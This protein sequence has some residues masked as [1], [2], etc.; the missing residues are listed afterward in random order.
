M[1]ARRPTSSRRRLDAESALPRRAL[2]RRVRPRRRRPRRRRQGA[3]ARASTRRCRP[4]RRASRRTC[5]PTRTTSPSSSTTWQSSTASSEGEIALAGRGRRANAG[6][7]TPTSSRSCCP[8]GI[9]LLASLDDRAAAPPH[10]GGVPRPRTPRRRPRQPRSSCSRSRGCGPSAPRLLGFPVHAAYVTAEQTA[11]SPEAVVADMLGRLAPPAARNAAPSRRLQR[12]APGDR[13]TSTRASPSP[14]RPHDWA[15]YSR[16][17]APERR[18]TSTR[19]PCAPYFEAERVLRDGVFF[20]ATQLYGLDLRRA[21][22]TSSAYHPDARVFE[23]HRGRRRARR[24]LRARPLHARLEARRRVDEPARVAVGP[25]RTAAR[26]SSTTSTCRSRR[27]ARRR[28]SARRGRRR[29][30]TSSA[31]PCTA[32]SPA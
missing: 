29:C 17:G 26:S 7:T 19:P 22:T 3:P 18:T 24:P 9:P 23:V 5:S 21:R 14:S 25:A 31:T 1:R 13:W 11:G 6:S 15:F 2:P 20:A 10:H 30:S 4:S 8:P 27:P 32:S 16:E 28:C 12:R